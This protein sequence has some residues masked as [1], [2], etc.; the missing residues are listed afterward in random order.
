MTFWQTNTLIQKKLILQ[1]VSHDVK[2][3]HWD[4]LIICCYQCQQYS[5]SQNMQIHL[6]MW[7]LH[8]NKSWRWSMLSQEWRKVQLLF[9]LQWSSLSMSRVMQESAESQRAHNSC[10]QQSVYM[11]CCECRIKNKEWFQLRLNYCFCYW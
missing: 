10:I 11:F 7:I 5:H 6:K 1:K 9:K 4:C 8:R 3:F 2:I